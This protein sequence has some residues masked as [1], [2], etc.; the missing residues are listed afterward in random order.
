MNTES[1][2]TRTSGAWTHE[3]HHKFS[4]MILDHA[5]ISVMENKAFNLCDGEGTE[6]V[7][8]EIINAT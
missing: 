4:R 8:R 6:R 5:S 3:L 1:V 7:T 2:P